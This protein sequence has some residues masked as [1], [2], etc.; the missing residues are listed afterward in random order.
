MG[1]KE[2]E[3]KAAAEKATADAKAAADK[4]QDD[5]I[6][7]IANKAITAQLKRDAAAREKA[8]KEREERIMAAIAEGRKA[9]EPAP[10]DDK[11][12]PAA[13]KLK[14]LEARLVERDRKLEEAAKAQEAEKAARLRDE[15]TAK[16]KDAMAAMDIKDPEDQR[17]ALA[18]LRE[19]KRI[20]R[21]DEGRVCFLVQK[22]GYVDKVPIADGIK[23]WVNTP[24]GKRYQPARGVGGSG[25]VAGK[26]PGGAAPAK[27]NKA[28]RVAEARGHLKNMFGKGE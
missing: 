11:A 13:A 28:E 5:R 24:A 22:D 12:D 18:V 23:D 2:D 3:E 16:T 10:K 7:E 27:G 14:E 4:A 15:E 6:A 19:D 21:D 26:K 8:D 20:G 17:A 9:S 25:Q 1:L